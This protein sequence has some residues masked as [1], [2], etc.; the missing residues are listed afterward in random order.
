MSDKP[1]E[2]DPHWL[3]EPRSR[4]WIMRRARQLEQAMNSEL[5][6]RWSSHCYLTYDSLIREVRDKHLNVF[7]RSDTVEGVGQPS[8]ILITGY[9]GKVKE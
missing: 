8:R 2:E 6:S 7:W 9:E 1:L 5:K 3:Y 4:E